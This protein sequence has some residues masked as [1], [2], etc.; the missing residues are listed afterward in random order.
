MSIVNGLLIPTGQFC[1]VTFITKAG[2][3]RKVNG[4]TG[5]NKYS[6]GTAKS[7]VNHDKFFLVYTRSGSKFFDAP[8]AID[9]AKIISIKAHGIRA[10]K[11]K[12]SIYCHNV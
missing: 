2:D 9:K 7:T 8:R 12:D 5:V 11:N 1:S 3:I 10:E 4:R 6:K